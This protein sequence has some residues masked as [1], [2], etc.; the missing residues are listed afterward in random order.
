MGFREE[1]AADAAALEENGRL[2]IL[3]EI[4]PEGHGLCRYD[5]REFL[6]FSSNDYM[7]IAADAELRREFYAQ[8]PDAATPELALSS[9]SSRLLTG[10][11]PAYVR[12]EEKLS[13]LYNRRAA[14][15]FNSGYHAN[16]GILPALSS[17]RDLILSDKLNH[18]SIIDGMRLADAEFRRYRHL[19]CEQLEK[20]LA[21]RRAAYRRVFLVT[22][23]VFSMD[24]DAADLKKLVGLKKKYDCILVVDEAPFGRRPRPEPG[25]ASPPS[26]ALRMTSIS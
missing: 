20:I 15:V 13:A 1:L 6:N 18:A 4:A 11:T 9:A 25:P 5:G 10:N 3:R 12:L 22:E 21:D 14:L 16:I 26:S 17:D 24:G 23:S 19:D 8:Y 7:G 2:R